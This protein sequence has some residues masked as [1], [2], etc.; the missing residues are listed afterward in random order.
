MLAL[1]DLVVHVGYPSSAV[2]QIYDVS[3]DTF[4]NRVVL[5]KPMNH[6]ARIEKRIAEDNSHPTYGVYHL[7]TWVSVELLDLWVTTDMIC[8]AQDASLERAKRNRPAKA[9]R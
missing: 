3:D 2:F 7:S 8:Q 5:L 6:R 9:G 4:G 1:N